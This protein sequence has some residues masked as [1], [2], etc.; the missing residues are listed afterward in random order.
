M[1]AKAIIERIQQTPLPE[2]LK[3]SRRMVAKMCSET[4]PP[5]MSIPP[6]ADD[7]DM[8][9]CQT[10]ADAM[11]TIKAYSEA[12]Q[13]PVDMLLF[14]PNCGE[15]H[16][17]E[18]KPDACETC[19]QNLQGC[20]CE[21]F[22]A[23]LNPPHKSHRC[24]YCNHVFRP[25]DVPT[26]GVL[27]IQT[28][29][30]ND[31]NPRPRYIKTAK[32]FYDAIRAAE[33]ARDEAVKRAEASERELALID[34]T[35]ARRPAIAVTSGRVD[36]IALACRTAA[37]LYDEVIQYKNALAKLTNERNAVRHIVQLAY[38]L[39]TYTAAINWNGEPNAQEWL[40]GLQQRIVEFQA[41]YEALYGEQEGIRTAGLSA[42]E[43]TGTASEGSKAP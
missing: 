1:S 2:R 6:S 42:K 39:S 20:A 26:N 43:I 22:T 9:I 30:K 17:D 34:E 27:Q 37:L 28:A 15:Q 21:T 4:R 29:G 25:A 31:G 23:W 13:K 41:A 38:D 36:K 11:E 35:L 32:D 7:E 12:Q 18:A 14:C 3:M 8:F 40:R 33:S 24:S 16:V 19:G 5:K 10:L